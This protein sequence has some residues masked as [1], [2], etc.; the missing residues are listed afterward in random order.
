MFLGCVKSKITPFLNL[1]EIASGDS[2]SL[3]M[4][5]SPLTPAR[6]WHLRLPKREENPLINRFPLPLGRVPLGVEGL[7]RTPLRVRVRELP[8]PGGVSAPVG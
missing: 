5:P 2:V 3:A 7:A 6:W 1:H 4:T 8:L